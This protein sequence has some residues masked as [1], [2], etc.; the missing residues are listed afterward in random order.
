MLVGV[1]KGSQSAHAQLRPGVG[2]NGERYTA[3]AAIA[4]L[5]KALVWS[6]SSARPM[7]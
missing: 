5:R 3:E 6:R 7:S 1:T 4:N 2:A